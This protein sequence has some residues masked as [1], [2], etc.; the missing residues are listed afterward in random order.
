MQALPFITVGI[1][2]YL[3]TNAGVECIDIS[4]GI[5]YR[6]QTIPYGTNWVKVSEGNVAT[7]DFLQQGSVN[8]YGSGSGSTNNFFPSGWN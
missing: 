2:K 1:P 5:K 4:S 8:E 7:T 3:S 6:Q